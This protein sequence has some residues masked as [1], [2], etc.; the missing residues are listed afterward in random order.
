MDLNIVL[1]QGEFFGSGVLRDCH[2]HVVK[3]KEKRGR[4]QGVMHG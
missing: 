4:P 3:P 2:V 1:G